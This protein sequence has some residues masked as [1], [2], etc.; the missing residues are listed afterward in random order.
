MTHEI[1][2]CDRCGNPGV[3]NVGAEGYCSVHLAEMY[4]RFDPAVFALNGVGLQSGLVRPEFGPLFY[5][6]TCCACDAT[7]AGVPGETCYWCASS[8]NRM[9]FDQAEMLLE[10]PDVDPDDRLYDTRMQAWA[11]RLA[12]GVD[13]EII[14]DIEATQAWK[15]RSRVSAA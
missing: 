14:T 10:P 9:I 5:D 1:W 15:R 11:E 6:L 13:A 4:A 8:Y 7:W 2:P 3:R 12:R